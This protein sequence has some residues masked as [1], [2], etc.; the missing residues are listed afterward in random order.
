MELNFFKNKI[1]HLAVFLCVLPSTMQAGEFAREAEVRKIYEDAAR[2]EGIPHS[3]MP[4]I[5]FADATNTLP[6]H[7]HHLEHKDIFWIYGNTI[8]INKYSFETIVYRQEEF[9]KHAMEYLKQYIMQPADSPRQAEIRKLFYEAAQLHK[10]PKEAIPNIIFTNQ[11]NTELAWVIHNTIFINNHHLKNPFLN[12][13]M[14]ALH[15]MTHVKHH[16]GYTKQG[17]EKPERKALAKK[18]ERRADETACHL[19]ACEDCILEFGCCQSDDSCDPEGYMTQ[20]DCLTM[21][22]KYK[23]QKCLTHCTGEL[24]PALVVAKTYVNKTCT[25]S[26]PTPSVQYIEPEATSSKDDICKP[27]PAMND[28]ARQAEV[29]KIYAD[30]AKDISVTLSDDSF[31]HVSYMSEGMTLYDPA[32]NRFR[33]NVKFF[34]KPNSTHQEVARREMLKIKDLQKSNRAAVPQCSAPHVAMPQPTVQ[35]QSAINTPA[36]AATRPIPAPQAPVRIAPALV[37]PATVIPRATAQPTAVNNQPVIVPLADHPMFKLL[38]E[39]NTNHAKL[40]ISNPTT[41]TYN[42][43]FNR[44]KAYLPPLHPVTTDQI[45]IITNYITRLSATD[46]TYLM[47][48]AHIKKTSPEYILTSYYQTNGNTLNSTIPVIDILVWYLKT[49]PASLQISQ[50]AITLETKIQTSTEPQS[51]LTNAVKWLQSWWS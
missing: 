48:L 9:A 14:T 21:A 29:L 13:K 27:C 6:A 24:T 15:E 39:Y 1:V 46:Y 17:L 20:A 49:H 51:T 16:D 3:K 38:D 34:D 23:G 4:T 45:Q 12:W 32:T 44:F 8:W 28:S 47:L 36:S 25:S 33:V 10:I 50:A 19:A 31:K 35:P 43:N 26:I 41:H 2:A 37:T 18:H 11:Q 7:K 40:A 5:I 30:A 42:W 22:I